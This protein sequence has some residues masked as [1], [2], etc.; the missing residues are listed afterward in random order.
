MHVVLAVFK[1]N[2]A[3]YLSGVLGYLFMAA[4]LIG[5]ALA[6]FNDS[7]FAN[8]LANPD[9]LSLWF[10]FL[11]VGLIP[12]IT[13]SSW[14]DERRFGT[15]EL[16]FTL[17]ATD[18]QILIGKYLAAVGVYTLTLLFAFLG[19]VIC[20]FV[21]G[22]PDLGLL[23]SAFVGYWLAGLALVA[24]GMVASAATRSPTVAYLL[25][26]ITAGVPAVIYLHSTLAPYSVPS[27][28]QDFSLGILSLPGIVYF[29]S[30]TV[31]MLFVTYVLITGRFWST[32]A[33]R[34]AALVTACGI[35]PLGLI[36]IL[37]LAQSYLP[38]EWSREWWVSLLVRVGIVAVLVTGVGIAAALRK[39]D[40]EWSSAMRYATEFLALGA[41][42]VSLNQTVRAWYLPVDLTA[43]HLYSITDTTKDVLSNVKDDRKVRINAFISPDVPKQYAATRNTL[44]GLLRTYGQYDNVLVRVVETRRHSEEAKEAK[45][46]QIEPREAR[47]D[48]GGRIVTKQ[49][50]MG[51]HLSAGGEEVP[52]PFF[53]Q[54]TPVEYELTRSIHTLT[55]AKRKR[56]GILRTDA[57]VSGGFDMSSF[58]QTPEWKFVTEL[59]KQYDVKDVEPTELATQDFDVLVAVM[60]SSL[61]ATE[62][63]GLVS[64]V[65]KGN[66]TLIIDDPFPLFHA[67]LAPKSGKPK[68]GGMFGQGP[69]PQEKAEGGSLKSLLDALDMEWNV[70][71]TVWDP[72]DPQVRLTE[73]FRA[74]DVVYVGVNSGA[75]PPFNPTNPITSGMQEIMLFYPGSLLT[76]SN[77]PMK[78]EALLRASPKAYTRN[79]DEYVDEAGGMFGMGG[80]QPKLDLE[81]LEPEPQQW[82]MAMQV[83]GDKTKD[84]SSKP[85]SAVFI[86][87][88]DVISDEFFFVRD[89]EW[90]A[91]ELDNIAFVL[92]AVDVLAGDPKNVELRKRRGQHRTLTRVEAVQASVNA[93]EIAK[94][95]E[96]KEG[97]EGFRTDKQKEFDDR[98]KAINEDS[99]L[100]EI[101]KEVKVETI[102]Q[103]MQR[104]LDLSVEDYK[105]EVEEDIA[106]VRD[107]ADMGRLAIQRRF[108]WGT[109]L[110]M[111]LPALILGLMVFG[112]RLKE[113]N[114][115]AVPDRMVKK[116]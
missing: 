68:Q 3:S 114:Q 85:V 100:S 30:L 54:G 60:P 57:K 79:W 5:V 108:Q 10:P 34:A 39:S 50:F 89:T 115:G 76:K 12:A 38:Q 65:K 67:G 36:V 59:K 96:L 105:R 63:P 43:E 53:D 7:F 9:Q 82:V 103:Q 24:A 62:L 14:A 31:L 40:R 94:I 95:R 52:I 1:R 45:R 116:R 106:E 102:R 29:L 87:D 113:E 109:V 73:I 66:P 75:N 13:M 8:N 69:P 42:L 110:G 93:D 49:V 104:Q 74:Y 86:A 32:G 33:G 23:V 51:V 16:L 47:A 56:V 99:S 20:L 25:G 22:S 98:I 101:E 58:R 55:Q 37:S 26:L 35:I 28:L 84:S 15:D 97:I 81:H 107:N 88:L 2:L 46:F 17:P 27:N 111:P 90:N 19:M 92:N 18:L 80:A 44:M 48:E 41:I 77:S 61:T 78:H 71:E 112:I 72:Y 11:L 21:M 83:K 4:F 70:G 64:Y 6:A 91:L